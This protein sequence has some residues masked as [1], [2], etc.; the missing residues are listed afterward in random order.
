MRKYFLL[1]TA[2]LLFCAL[3]L[4]STNYSNAHHDGTAID[5]REYMPTKMYPYFTD[6]QINREPKGISLTGKFKVTDKEV[7][8]G[9]DNFPYVKLIN[10][11]TGE[12]FSIILKSNNL[13]LLFPLIRNSLNQ[14]VSIELN[15]QGTYSLEALFKVMVY[16]K[17][18]E[19]N[20]VTTSFH[21]HKDIEVR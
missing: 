8:I 12:F 6:I 21:I 2:F 1:C 19:I 10:K 9:G 13:N 5:E 7:K 17:S 15:Q 3:F 14:N 11:E 4:T 18:S 20:P 16:R